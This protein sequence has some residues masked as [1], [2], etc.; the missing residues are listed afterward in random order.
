MDLQLDGKTALITGGTSGIGLAIAK[1]FAAEGCNIITFSRSEYRTEVARSALNGFNVHV[2]VEKF[3]AKSQELLGWIQSLPTLDIFVPNVSALSSSWPDS[4]ETDLRATI[5]LTESVL[6]LL[7]KSR[8]AAITYIGSKAASV[9][10]PGFESYGATK[11]AVTHYMKSLSQRLHGQ[12]R[13]NTVSPGDTFVLG[14]FWDNIRQVAPDT[15]RHTEAMNPMRRFCSPEEVA[16][17]VAF[18]SSPAASFINGAN[19]LVDG[20]ATAHLHG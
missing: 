2:T 3:D 20:G 7:A 16:T 11:A 4:I 8:A 12:V 14:G 6:P 1:L 10:T 15:Y 19:L 18:V 5:D 17:A 9:A 13:V